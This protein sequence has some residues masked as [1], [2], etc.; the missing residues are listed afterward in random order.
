MNILDIDLDFFLK[1]RYTDNTIIGERLSVKDY[2]IWKEREVVSF[3]ETNCGLSTQMPIKG[4]TFT[5]HHELFYY[6]ME[7][8]LTDINLYHIDAHEDVYQNHYIEIMR[9]YMNL[10]ENERGNLNNINGYINEGNFIIFL[11]TCHKLESIKYI[12][13]FTNYG[14]EVMGIYFREFNPK[15][16]KLQIGILPQNYDEIPDM[17]EIRKIITYPNNEHPIPF[18]MID[19]R[20]FNAKEIDFDYVFLTKSPEYTPPEADVFIPLIERYIK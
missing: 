16:E 15:S 18:Q 8:N 4:A 10:P 13:D 9:D 14:Y 5:H 12:N 11:A 3:L 7:N 6:V 2:P 20:N 19:C 17:E 1:E